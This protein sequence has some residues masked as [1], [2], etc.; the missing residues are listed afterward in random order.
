MPI[1]EIETERE[2]KALEVYLANISEV[3]NFSDDLSNVVD[4]DFMK[5][6]YT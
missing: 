5:H 1:R 2:A 4:G 6:F 3:T